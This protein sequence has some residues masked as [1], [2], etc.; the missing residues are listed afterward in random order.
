MFLPKKSKDKEVESKSQVIEGISRLICT[1][2][3]QQTMLRGTFLHRCTNMSS[4]CLQHRRPQRTLSLS[5]ADDCDDLTFQRCQVLYSNYNC[6][7]SNV[8]S[9]K[10]WFN[11]NGLKIASLCF[12]LFKKGRFLLFF[13]IIQYV[14]FLFICFFGA[15]HL[16][17]HYIVGL[18][19]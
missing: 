12:K 18:S 9:Q 3:Q 1:A 4:P 17:L 10:P 2:K 16:I 14:L 15:S 6:L 5:A 7:N 19:T 11:F 13:Y 8:T